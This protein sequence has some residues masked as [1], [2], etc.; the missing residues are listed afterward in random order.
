MVNL[1]TRTVNTAIRRTYLERH[2]HKI[3]AVIGSPRV[4][5][6]LALHDDLSFQFL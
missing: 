2:L 4:A 1:I 3:E 5:F 6:S